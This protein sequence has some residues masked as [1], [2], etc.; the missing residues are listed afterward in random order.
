M[1]GGLAAEPG[2]GQGPPGSLLPGGVLL[3]DA[4]PNVFG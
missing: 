1:G 4:R 3:P 2:S